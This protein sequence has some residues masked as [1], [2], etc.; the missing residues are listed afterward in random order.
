MIIYIYSKN[1]FMDIFLYLIIVGS[2]QFPCLFSLICFHACC[3]EAWMTL[4]FDDMLNTACWQL[5]FCV[6]NLKRIKFHVG[7]HETIA[8][9]LRRLRDCGFCHMDPWIAWLGGKMDVFRTRPR[10]SS[11]SH[12]ASIEYIYLG[13]QSH[14]FW[15]ST[16]APWSYQ[17]IS[18]TPVLETK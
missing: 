12:V 7:E 16:F 2:S 18:Q 15:F 11:D 13:G 17:V 1:M 5:H 4:N 10:F 9:S 3:M 8:R 6:Q 14:V